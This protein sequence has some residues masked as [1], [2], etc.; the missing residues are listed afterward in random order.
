VVLTTTRLR[1]FWIAGASKVAAG[2][3]MTGLGA[4]G[5]VEFSTAGKLLNRLHFAYKALRSLKT[6]MPWI[7]YLCSFDPG[8]CE[9]RNVGTT[10][11]NSSLL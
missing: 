11:V 7:A 1:I 6:I 8:D 9:R 3:A 4:T 2:I 5:G 10:F